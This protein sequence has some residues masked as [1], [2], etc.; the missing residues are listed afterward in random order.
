MQFLL[1]PGEVSE[2]S[3]L[4]KAMGRYVGVYRNRKP[5]KFLIAKSIPVRISPGVS[6]K[7]LWEEHERGMKT[8]RR[9]EREF[10]KAGKKLEHLKFPAKSLIDLKRELAERILRKCEFCERRCGIDR[11]KGEKGFCG[12]TDQSLLSSEFVH[13]GE[14]ASIIPSHTFFFLGCNFYCVYCQNWRISRQK[15]VGTPVTGKELAGFAKYRRLKEGTR[16]VNLVGG[17]PIPNMHTVLDMLKCL[18]VNVPIVWNSN[19]YMSKKGMKLLDGVIDVYLSDFKYGNDRCAEMLSKVKNYW[20]ITTRNHL[21]AKRQAEIL[22][23]HLVLPN[24]LECCTSRIME[25]VGKNMGKV[26]MNIMGQYHPEFEVFG[27]EGMGRRT[28]TEE[29]KRA[30][31]LARKNGVTNLET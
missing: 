9:K 18:D 6:D 25:W 19:M 11:T 3:G 28:E 26:R 12:L 20:K 10:D 15:E 21:L 31:E 27:L 1:Y 7:E 13:M 30:L 29:I 4:K 16:N 8:F 2:D 22:I 24:H 23:R 14:E 17:D 5:A